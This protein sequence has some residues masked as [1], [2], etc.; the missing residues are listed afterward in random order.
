MRD[1]V[2]KRLELA[3]GGRELAVSRGELEALAREL[4]GEGRAGLRELARRASLGGLGLAA[5]QPLA[6]PAMLVA[7]PLAPDLRLDPCADDVAAERLRY[8]VI[9]TLGEGLE[10]H[11]A[12]IAGGHHDERD[13]AEVRRRLDAPTGVEARQARA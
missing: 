3:V 7:H 2:A 6:N 5:E 11:V 13:I 4:L 10:D 9:G 8:E 12:A 1:R